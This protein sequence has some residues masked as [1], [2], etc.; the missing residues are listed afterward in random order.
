MKQARSQ[1]KLFQN[2]SLLMFFCNFATDYFRTLK[3]QPVSHVMELMF[4][5][6]ISAIYLTGNTKQSGVFTCKPLLRT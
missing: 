6:Q 5:V 3:T 4:K 2:A 1:N